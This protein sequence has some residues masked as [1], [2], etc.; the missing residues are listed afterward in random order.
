MMVVRLELLSFLGWS[1]CDIDFVSKTEL[2]DGFV[3]AG[4]SMTN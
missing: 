1:M 3:A 2:T 4:P